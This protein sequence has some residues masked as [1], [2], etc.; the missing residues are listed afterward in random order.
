M[1]L[2]SILLSLALILNGCSTATHTLN[3]SRPPD[4]PLRYQNTKY[5]LTFYLPASWKGYSLLLQEWQTDTNLV[6]QGGPSERGMMISI[7]HPQWTQSDPYQDIPIVVFSRNQWTALKKGGLWPNL[8]AGGVM[9]EM[10]HN[11]RYV[12]ALNSR[13]TWGELKGWE[14]VTRIVSRNIS[15]NAQHMFPE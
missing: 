9:D 13:Y 6:D 15:L 11:D 5:G 8:Y 7:R 4:L 14:E 3:A 1:R 2:K 10:W 12:F